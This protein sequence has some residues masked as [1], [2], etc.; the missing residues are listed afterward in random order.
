MDATVPQNDGYRFVYSLPFAPDRILIEDTYFSDDQA[1]SRE[2]LRAHIDDYTR[3][4]GWKIKRV[5]REEDGILPMILAGDLP[6]LLRDLDEGAPKIGLGAALFNPATG[7]SLPDAVR[8]TERL[9]KLDPLTTETARATIQNYLIETW[10]HLGF[11]RL[12]NRMLF[13]AGRK[14]RR[15]RVLER[16]YR[17]SQGTIERLYRGQLTLGDRARILTGKPPV[18]ITEAMR[19]LSERRMLAEA[20]AAPRTS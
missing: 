18:P 7:Y 4:Q 15:N 2:T 10:G 5:I 14:D 13:R 9:A 8:L 3:E 1:L 11:Q 19:C 12:L 17:L 6:G 20:Q 16:F